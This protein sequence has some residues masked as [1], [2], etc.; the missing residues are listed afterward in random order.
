MKP[1]KHLL[2]C[3]IAIAVLLFGCSAMAGGR[4]NIQQSHSAAPII[5][6]SFAANTKLSSCGYGT[7]IQVIN[8]SDFIL[9]VG[10]DEDGD[11]LLPIY[12]E[13]SGRNID[14]IDSDA[15]YSDLHISIYAENDLNTW[16][17]T[18]DVPNC[19][20]LVLYDAYSSMK[21]LKTGKA[22][23]KKPLVKLIRTSL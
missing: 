14:Y 6:N 13:G 17:L 2:Q 4:A 20:T 18:R 15:Y 3:C 21:T 9:Y 19:E 7:H 23:A 10:V 11:Y 22:N 1:T 5:K 16:I 12:P 8:L